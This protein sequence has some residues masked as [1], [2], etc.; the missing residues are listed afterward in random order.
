M[1]PA[2]SHAAIAFAA[3]MTIFIDD[4]TGAREG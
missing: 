2:R 1:T 4:S 3:P